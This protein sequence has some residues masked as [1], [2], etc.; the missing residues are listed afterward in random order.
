MNK[1]ERE[2]KDGSTKQKFKKTTTQ[3]RR[4]HQKLRKKI[5]RRKNNLDS[6]YNL[7]YVML[8]GTL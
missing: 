1:Q 2:K 7:Y 5:P 3:S 6:L 8:T 4:N